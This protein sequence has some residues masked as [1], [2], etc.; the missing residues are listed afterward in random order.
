MF[1]ARKFWSKIQETS[2]YCCHVQMVVEAAL[3]HI[4]RYSYLYRYFITSNTQMH[5]SDL[6]LL[7]PLSGLCSW[8]S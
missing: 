6:E 4:E 1:N 2:E 8:A 7:S 5:V 3:G